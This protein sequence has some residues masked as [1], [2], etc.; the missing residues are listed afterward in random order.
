VAIAIVVAVAA[1]TWDAENAIDRTH[2][3]ADAGAD[4]A[5]NRRAHRASDAATVIRTLS[6]A[7]LHTA[8]NALRMRRTGISTGYAAV[9]IAFTRFIIVNSSSL[10]CEGITPA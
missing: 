7:S 8:H 1:R 3:A 10:E 9:L 4:S 6:S 2:R 5:A